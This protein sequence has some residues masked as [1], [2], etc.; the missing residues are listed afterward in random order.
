MKLCGRQPWQAAAEGS[1]LHVLILLALALGEVLG[2]PAEAV[3]LCGRQPWQAAAEGSSLHVLLHLVLASFGPRS[4]GEVPGRGSP[5][6][7]F[8]FMHV[9]CSL[10]ARS[11][12]GR[13]Q[14]SVA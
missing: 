5:S 9:V 8:T 6:R 2:G 11:F 7:V 1:S 13:E 14:L 3:K 4:L 10:L 12:R